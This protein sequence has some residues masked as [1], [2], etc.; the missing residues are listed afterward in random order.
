[1]MEDIAIIV[2]LGLT[3]RFLFGIPK[4]VARVS[5]GAGFSRIE[6]WRGREAEVCVRMVRVSRTV[7]TVVAGLILFDLMAG[8]AS[9]FDTGPLVLLITSLYGV[10]TAEWWALEA[11]QH[12]N[13]LEK[14]PGRE[15]EFLKGHVWVFRILLSVMALGAL[16]VWN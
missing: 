3:I 6:K 16:A 1:M 11:A 7:F 10:A 8:R 5:T 2:F 14:W 4:W 12:A 15:D 13:R 9:V